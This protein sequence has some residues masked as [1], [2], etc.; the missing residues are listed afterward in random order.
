MMQLGFAGRVAIVT[1]GGGG[2]GSAV[3][4]RLSSEGAKVVVVDL[5]GDAAARTAESLGAD[6][7]AGEVDDY[8]RMVWGAG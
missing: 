2:I 7:L 6:A 5:D 3:A 1:G 8:D 4:A